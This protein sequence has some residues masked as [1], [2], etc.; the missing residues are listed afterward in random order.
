MPKTILTI[1]SVPE[2][3]EDL[4]PLESLFLRGK[5]GFEDAERVRVATAQETLDFVDSQPVDLVVSSHLMMPGEAAKDMTLAV[6]QKNYRGSE[7]GGHNQEI[8][9]RVAGYTLGEIFRR[10]D[11]KPAALI[12]PHFGD[13][14]RWVTCMLLGGLGPFQG[15]IHT[16]DD[17]F[18]H[19]VSL[20]DIE[21]STWTSG[22]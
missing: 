20:A 13:Q 21:R 17:N 8:S 16:C 19:L 12:Y 1:Q 7:N 6:F 18:S 9:W 5:S 4:R 11:P 14:G 22:L 2:P 15:R 3:L 10:R